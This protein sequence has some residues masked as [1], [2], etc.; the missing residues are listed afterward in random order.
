MNFARLRL[1]ARGQTAATWAACALLLVS[2]TSAAQERAP[3]A[4]RM[5]LGESASEYWDL[6]ARFESGHLLFARFLV[7]NEGPGEHTA[8]AVGHLLFPDGGHVAFR[9]GRQ[10]GRWRLEA[11][12]ERLVV[13]SSLLDL[14][15][16]RRRYEV[17]KERDGIRIRLAIEA[18][19]GAGVSAP[20]GGL[21][22]RLL[23]LA[24][25][26]TGEIQVRERGM[27]A[28]QT[29][30]G[31]AWLIHTWLDEPE[32]AVAL[33][34]IDFLAFDGD[35]AL[36]LVDVLPVPGRAPWR[37]LAVQEASQP[38]QQSAAFEAVASGAAPGRGEPQYPLPGALRL[39][40]PEL[41]GRIDLARVLLRHE[42][43]EDLP[44]PFR[45]LFSLKTRP[46]R[47]WVESPFALKFDTPSS[48]STRE[49][50]GTGI[51]AVTFSNPL[52][53]TARRSPRDAGG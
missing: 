36:A 15:S 17:D 5:S 18:G 40:N 51:A 37:W 47:A 3:L 16:P 9:N 35:V 34:R 10:R 11:G 20:A 31:R 32:S 6:T 49:L 4:A 26:V 43:L 46:R 50:R 48:R 27:S 21:S 8:V 42:P 13:G 2:A 12:G 33:R 38:V 22:L 52:P 24:A 19:S 28:P 1:A 53:E 41:S 29:L 39:E 7:T 25:P 45:F 44:Q 30:R 14:R 23:D